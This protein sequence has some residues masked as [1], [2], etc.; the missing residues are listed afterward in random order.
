MYTLQYFINC[1]LT[2]EHVLISN[3]SV[4]FYLEAH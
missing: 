4:D 3:G 1:R 2:V